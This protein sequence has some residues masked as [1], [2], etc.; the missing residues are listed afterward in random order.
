MLQT[1]FSLSFLVDDRETLTNFNYLYWLCLSTP[2]TINKKPKNTNNLGLSSLVL[3]NKLNYTSTALQRMVHNAI[4][5]KKPFCYLQISLFHNRC[6]AIN[7]IGPHNIDVIS[8]IF[9]LL[10][11]DGH[12]NNI[13]GEGMRISVKKSIIHK[14]YL[15]FLYDFF[16]TKGYC[17]KLEPRKYTRTIK[18]IN[19]FYFGYD[20]NTYTFRSFVWIYKLFYKNGKKILPL[21]IEEYFTP[22][23]L[24]IFI[25]DDGG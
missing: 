15:F 24:A 5:L 25:C 4:Y 17:S 16:L 14:E 10:L 13:S 18:G 7:R 21:N 23:T 9:G 22:L 8:V 2:Q 1:I 11:G 19:K 20:F 6:R 3:T 12:G